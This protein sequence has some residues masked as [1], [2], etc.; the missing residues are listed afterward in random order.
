MNKKASKEELQARLKEKSQLSTTQTQTSHKTRKTASAGS[1]PSSELK[2]SYSKDEVKAIKGLMKTL[3]LTEEKAYETI[4]A[5]TG[6][7]LTP[8][9]Q[10]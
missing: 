7:R 4:K 6:G 3:K 8:E 5:M 1:T 9:G 10:K 2:G